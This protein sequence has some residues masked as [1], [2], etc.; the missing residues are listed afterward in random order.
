[1]TCRIIWLN[2]LKYYSQCLVA[3]F[4]ARCPAGGEFCLWTK[5]AVQRQ[6]SE[7]MKLFTVQ[8]SVTLCC[9]AGS[10]HDLS[11]SC[12]SDVLLYRANVL[13][14][15]GQFLLSVLLISLVTSNPVLVTLLLVLLNKIQMLLDLTGGWWR[16]EKMKSHKTSC[17][18]SRTNS[19]V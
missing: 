16:T 18:K 5:P 19:I 9:P 15:T 14:C 2:T 17:G 7:Q 12:F 13:P 1:M 3:T 11:K 10:L 4:P 6:H 8:S